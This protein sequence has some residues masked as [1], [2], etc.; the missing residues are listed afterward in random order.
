MISFISPAVSADHLAEVISDL[1]CLESGPLVPLA[2]SMD[3]FLKEQAPGAKY[4]LS[5]C[6]GAFS[7]GQAGLLDA[8][9][10][11]TNKANYKFCVVRHCISHPKSARLPIIRSPE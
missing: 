7:L 1:V 9:K 3:K 10:A 6:T 5:V 4:I 11:T 8:K 2:P